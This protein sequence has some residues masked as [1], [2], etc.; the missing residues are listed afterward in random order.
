[1]LKLIYRIYIPLIFVFLL[2]YTAK[3]NWSD[4]QWESVIEAD[5]KGYYAYL[6]ALL[7]YGDLNFGFYDKV[8]VENTYDQ[9]LIYDYR[10]YYEGRCINKYYAG[11]SFLVLPFFA[12]AHLI[13]HFYGYPTDGYSRL[14]VISITIAAL[15]YLLIGL[16]AL[17]RTFFLF[18]I[19]EFNSLIVISTLIFGT[20]LFY[21]SI[22][23]V[24]MT[25]VYSFSMISIFIYQ[26]SK[27]FNEFQGKRI[28]YGAI[29]LGLIIL[30]RPINAIIIFSIPFLSQNVNNFMRGLKNYFLRWKI[31]MLSIVIILSICSIQLIIYKWQTGTFFVY[32][33]GKEGFNFGSPQIANFLFSYK[34]GFFLYTPICLISL[35][36]FASIW[37]DK[38]KV[39]TLFCFLFFVVYT[40]SSWW[41]WY[42]GGSFS[43]RVM[44]DFLPFYA[45]LLG[46]LLQGTSKT[47]LRGTCFTVFFLLVLLNQIQTLQYRYYVIHWS[48]MD[49]ESYWD[50]FLDIE[51]ILNRNIEI[52]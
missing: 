40:L 21:Y 1:M 24:G 18:G 38:F 32:S 19:S 4:G 10:A 36:G 9:N 27:Y 47:F 48:N 37:K 3:T 30:I 15:F 6:P 16:M 41:M 45:I 42:Y 31:L 20:N 39:I 29:F 43:S 49:K 14:Y 28:V 8:E 33:Y 46:L 50:T 34:K 23:E 51:P 17:R 44:V 11:E 7:I 5:A 26:V 2:L 52:E 12:T 25:H 22:G 35:F 13:S